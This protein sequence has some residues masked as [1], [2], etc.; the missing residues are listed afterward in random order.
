MPHISF[1]ACMLVAATSY[2]LQ[3][4]DGE[5]EFRRELPPSDTKVSSD[6]ADCCVFKGE[7]KNI[8]YVKGKKTTMG[9]EDLFTRCLYKDSDT[10]SYTIPDSTSL[11]IRSFECGA[12]T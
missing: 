5:N 2:A 6:A 3:L 7:E 4:N 10:K 8:K 1:F 11:K 9:S 12:N